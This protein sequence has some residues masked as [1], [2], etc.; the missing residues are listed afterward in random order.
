MQ[1]GQLAAA[2]P[3]SSAGA[4]LAG[5]PVVQEL[6]ELMQKVEAIKNE[7]EVMESEIKNTTT[8]MRKL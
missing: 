1:Q 2:L 5:S 4:A 6:R 8:D 3:A 7:R